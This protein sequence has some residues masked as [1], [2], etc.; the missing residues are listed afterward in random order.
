MGVVYEAT[1]EM[2]DRRVAIKLIHPLAGGAV[3][4]VERLE[5][6]AQASARLGHPNIVPVLDFGRGAD[7]TGLP[8]LVMQL[9]TGRSL[10]D[11]LR[12]G[13]LATGRAIDVAVQ[14]LEGLA[15]AH[16]AGVIHRDLKPA[17]LFVTPLGPGRELVR[18]LDFGLA[19]LLEDG[20]KQLTQYGMSL[21]TPAYMAPERIQGERPTPACDLYSIGVCLFEAL[22]GRRPFE[23]ASPIVLQGRV[24][25]VEAPDL[26]D[27]C[28]GLPAELAAIVARALAK[29]P[30]DR[31][32][33]ALEMR[34]A[35]LAVAAQLD[36][37]QRMQLAARPESVQARAPT[38]AVTAI[39]GPPDG[40]LDPRETRRLGSMDA[41]GQ[42]R[43]PAILAPAAPER[44][45][46]A[47]DPRPAPRT[48]APGGP[49]TELPT[50][51]RKPFWRPFA[52]ALAAVLAVGLALLALLL[53][54]R[55][56]PGGAARPATAAPPASSEP[57]ASRPTPAEPVAPEVEPAAAPPSERELQPEAPALDGEPEGAPEAVP[58]PVSRR[59]P[60]PLPRPRVEPLDRELRPRSPPRVSGTEVIE[61]EW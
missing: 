50:I 16:E 17:N 31:F 45:A 29:K 61:P 23:D 42:D 37:A 55:P 1:D 19:Y 44:R 48:S 39:S 46:L 7:G 14:T 13:P 35:L 10:Q 28:V 5:R 27:V 26:S 49:P 25:L 30:D 22:A 54:V 32:A 2:L 56:A 33:S 38:Q 53:F 6:E 40:L 52:G 60:R 3:D 21:G 8:Y 51:V 12:E 59:S 4:L 57:V 20:A 41:P 24:L 9:L 15:V 47:T 11:V 34:D 36:A 43:E 18:I 58:A